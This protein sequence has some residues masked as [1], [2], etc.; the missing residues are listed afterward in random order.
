M[1]ASEQERP[2]VA[3]ARAAWKAGQA[4]LDPA[5]LVFI[6]DTGAS[7]KMTRLY[8][9]APQ[10]ERPEGPILYLILQPLDHVGKD[11]LAA[12]FL[13]GRRAVIPQSQ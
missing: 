6:D 5:K 3:A 1:H 2:D 8:G 12:V 13:F 9:R 7:T 11:R 10:G 4:S